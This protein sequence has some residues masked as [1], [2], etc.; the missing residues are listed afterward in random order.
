MNKRR[1]VITGMGAATAFGDDLDY[2]WKQLISGKS[3]IRKIQNFDA[4]ELGCQIAGEIKITQEG[5]KKTSGGNRS[6]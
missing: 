3:A 1:V 4:S 6:K 2:I 5:Q